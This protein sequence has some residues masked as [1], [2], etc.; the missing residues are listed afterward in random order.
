MNKDW[1]EIAERFE[2]FSRLLLLQR[3]DYSFIDRFESVE[4]LL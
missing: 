1:S 2:M 4:S 3:V